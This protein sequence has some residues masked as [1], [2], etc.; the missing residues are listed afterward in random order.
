MY[1]NRI[2]KLLIVLVTIAFFAGGIV[3]FL[4]QWRETSVNLSENE[5]LEYI[6]KSNVFSFTQ[7]DDMLV[8][9]SNGNEDLEIKYSKLIPENL[10]VEDYFK[11]WKVIAEGSKNIL[12]PDDCN[13]LRFV[14]IRDDNNK[15]TEDLIFS[16]EEDLN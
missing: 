2:V 13:Y 14:K 5:H 15:P 12:P 11:D 10:S 8:L 6:I 16:C 3:L 7:S 9:K 1:L 4:V